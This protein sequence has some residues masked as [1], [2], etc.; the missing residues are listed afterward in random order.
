MSLD[1]RLRR[2]CELAAKN[3]ARVY[4]LASDMGGIRIHRAEQGAV[5]A[6]RVD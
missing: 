1:L 4:N 5:H 3:V 6:Q 2:D